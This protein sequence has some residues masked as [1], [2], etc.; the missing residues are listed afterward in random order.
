[1][2]AAFCQQNRCNPMR[3]HVRLLFLLSLVVFAQLIVP[4]QAQAQTRIVV[5]VGIDVGHGNLHLSPSEINNFTSL[6]TTSGAQILYNTASLNQSYLNSLDLLLISSPQ[7]SFSASELATISTWFNSGGSVWISGGNETLNSIQ[8]SN[9]ILQTISSQLRFEYGYATD[10]LFNLNSTVPD[11]DQLIIP[12]INHKDGLQTG[13]TTG[14]RT[15]YS[16]R[17]DPIITFNGTSYAKLNETL[18]PSVTWLAETSSTS[19]VHNSSS[20]P[21]LAYSGAKPVRIPVASVETL[22]KGRVA[23]TGFPLF[24]QFMQE[25]TY[26]QNKP[27]DN[28]VL[29]K[30]LI[31]WLSKLTLAGELE[32]SIPEIRGS[33][34]PL[35]LIYT[36][37][38]SR[39]SNQ[40]ELQPLINLLTDIGFTA[41]TFQILGF[42]EIKNATVLIMETPHLLISS[43][44][45][46]AINLWIQQGNRLLILASMADYSLSGSATESLSLNQVLQALRS[47]LRFEE[48]SVIDPEVNVGGNPYLTLASNINHVSASTTSLTANIRS[49]NMQFGTILAAANLT[50]PTATFLPLE[51]QTYLNAATNVTWIARTSNQSA[52]FDLDPRFPIQAHKQYQ[53]GSYIV[54]AQE[55]YRADKYGDTLLLLGG[56]IFADFSRLLE[57]PTVYGYPTDN[58]I[59]VRNIF[60]RLLTQTQI[61]TEIS[62]NA[63]PTQLTEGGNVTLNAHFNALQTSTSNLTEI[64]HVPIS[65]ANVTLT[66]SGTTLTT[67]NLSNLTYTATGRPTGTGSVTWSA[68][69]S[70]ARY[71]SQSTTG[72][73]Q[74]NPIPTRF[75]YYVLGIP[76]VIFIAVTIAVLAKKTR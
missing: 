56:P 28:R 40:S 55:K 17:P 12:L 30:N 26:R 75:T 22:P 4:H 65:P 41:Q 49:L 3:N 14:I 44:E 52:I 68:S 8:I 15:L 1:M 24:S 43:N 50:D 62:V 72:T 64:D 38:N 32:A 39:H 66:L 67:K 23:L 45:T 61:R 73:V 10:P 13:I 57:Y 21:L 47:S 54:A 48:G 46:D 42:T 35:V 59:F 2:N 27:N 6:L 63:L 74:V 16:Y 60:M 20:T 70:A 58:L 36:G 53:T 33:G 9:T 29:V 69:A 31:T 7:T 37:S 71:I 19:R 34:Q 25:F 51:N 76:I 11:Q 5:K 18:T